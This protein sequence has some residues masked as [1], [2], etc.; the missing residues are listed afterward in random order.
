MVYS[1]LVY[2]I[3]KYDSLTCKSHCATQEMAISI[4]SGQYK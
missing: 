1:V 3:K 4:L 2:L